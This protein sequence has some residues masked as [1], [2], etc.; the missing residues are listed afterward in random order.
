MVDATMYLLRSA[1]LLVSGSVSSV[2]CSLGKNA[3]SNVQF[4]SIACTCRVGDPGILVQ[5]G[6]C[7]FF[8]WVDSGKLCVAININLS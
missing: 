5:S 2:H 1:V 6:S 4:L 7:F 3:I 8:Y